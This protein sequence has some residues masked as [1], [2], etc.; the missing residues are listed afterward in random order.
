MIIIMTDNVSTISP[1]RRWTLLTLR[2]LVIIASI[3]LIVF[4]SDDTF[5]NISFLADR[6]YMEVQW[7]ICMFFLFDFF[8]EWI[9]A[10]KKW[11]Y[12][13]THF[14]L[15]VVSIPY[16]N[17][18]EYYDIHLSCEMSYLIRFMP[19]VRAA[20]ALF[21]I[22]LSLSNNKIS[23]MFVCYIV[24]LVSTIY[25]FSLVFFI[26]E[27][28]VNPDVGSFW[29]A[30]W[31]AFMNTTTIGCYISPV[32]PT[33]K[34]IAVILSAEGLM[35][36][37]VFTVYLTNVITRGNLNGAVGED[38]SESASGTTAQAAHS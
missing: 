37:P 13:A 26:E 32:T 3:V 30:L 4:I 14:M 22:M 21:I 16:L 25:F 24:L 10:R 28:Y 19:L 36:F 23:S 17:L 27:H 12:L 5:R 38:M 20:Y 2:V 1:L 29:S 11:R 15:F 9:L 18:I 35:L 6:T 31:W 7:W 8:V 34:V 33:G